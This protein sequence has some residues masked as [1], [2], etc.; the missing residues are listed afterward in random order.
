VVPGATALTRRVAEVLFLI[1]E[2]TYIP[3][4]ID[5]LA[6]LLVE[7]TTDDLG[8]LRN[9]VQPE[10]EKLRHA[11]MVSRAG[12]EYEFLTGVRRT[13]EDEVSQIAMQYKVQDLDAGLAKFVSGD[14]IGFQTVQ[15]KGAEFPVRIF[16]D[17]TPITKEGQIEVRV[18]SP[19]AGGKNRVGVGG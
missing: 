2:I 10:L 1:R 14:G 4:T 6:R 15:F 17:D 13:F 7:Q 16:F 12:E 18:A 5:N 3:R 9:R 11:R 19:L 8:L